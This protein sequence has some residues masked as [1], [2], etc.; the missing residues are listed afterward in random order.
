AVCCVIARAGCGGSP[1]SA[2]STPPSAPPTPRG[3]W[4]E[5]PPTTIGEGDA[6]DNL[7][8]GSPRGGTGSGSLRGTPSQQVYR[9]DLFGSGQ[10][11][12][13]AIEFFAHPRPDQHRGDAV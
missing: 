6:N 10:L 13:T 5:A 3:T 7:A 2:P 4:V 1:P 12:L 9:G 8:N 11:R